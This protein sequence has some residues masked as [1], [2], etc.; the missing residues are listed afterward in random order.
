M[1]R[2]MPLRRLTRRPAFAVAVALTALVAC[3]DGAG[4]RG[5]T[6]L[7]LKLTDAPGDI[8]HAFVTITEVHLMGSDGKVVLRDTPF[9]ADLLTLAGTTA[10]L[11]TDA[12]VPSDTY[13][14]LRFVISGACLAVESESG[15]SDIYTTAGYDSEPCGGDA[16]GTLQA[17]SYAQ[18][19]LKV[20]LDGDALV[21]VG[22]Q[23]ILLVDF[24]VQQSFGHVAGQSG[25]WVMHPVVTGGE[26][27][28]GDG[29]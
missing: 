25:M 12:D 23:K 24:D 20:T 26:I 3:G 27:E 5:T 8:Q 16:T 1:L 7:S 11:V 18:S 2:S 28:A 15:G 14:E 10:D 9:T 4:P 22:P 19:G 17:P 29:V 21:I 13:S 6:S